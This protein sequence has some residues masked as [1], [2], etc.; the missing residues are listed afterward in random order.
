MR[1]RKQWSIPPSERGLPNL[2]LGKRKPQEAEEG[3][4]GEGKEDRF[5]DRTAIWMSPGA[6]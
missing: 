6:G 4:I 2:Y 1:I 3:L 5:T